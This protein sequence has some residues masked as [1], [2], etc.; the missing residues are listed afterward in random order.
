MELS[1]ILGSLNRSGDAF[2]K[3][4]AP[5]G[6]SLADWFDS[7]AEMVS[8]SDR[9]LAGGSANGVWTS[10]SLPKIEMHETFQATDPTEYQPRGTFPHPPLSNSQLKCGRH[11]NHPPPSLFEK[12]DRHILRM[13]VESAFRGT[14]NAWPGKDAARFATFVSSIVDPLGLDLAISAEWK[15]FLTKQI[16]PTD[17][18][19]FEYSAQD[20]LDKRVGHSAILARAVLLL[21]IATGS[22]LNLIRSA[23]VSGE[24]L[25]FWWSQLGINRGLWD[26]AKSRADLLDLWEDI[27]VLFQ[28]VLTFRRSTP[29]GQQTFQL[30]G[31]KIPQVVSGLGGCERVAI[32]SSD[33]LGE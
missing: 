9:R 4:I 20:P 6:I 18:T 32:W 2:S 26:G 12:I 31:D 19:I 33:A 1:Q 30:F 16:S 24:Q 22:T 15:S 27:A 17:P 8:L 25:E 29:S 5:S 13:T 14:Y 3:I 23:G 11:A 21:R 28:D 7:L 10:L